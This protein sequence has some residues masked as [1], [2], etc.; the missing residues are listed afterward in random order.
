MTTLH[1]PFTD[2]IVTWINNTNGRY[3]T[4]NNCVVRQTGTGV[5]QVSKEAPTGRIIAH[6]HTLSAALKFAQD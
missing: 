5:I 4:W 3:F 6:F 2:D 1:I